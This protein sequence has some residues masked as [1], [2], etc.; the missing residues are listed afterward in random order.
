[1]SKT[2]K[3]IYIYRSDDLSDES[4]KNAQEQILDDLYGEDYVF[5]VYEDSSFIADEAESSIL[6]Q[7]YIKE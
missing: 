5:I 4:I 3:N 6:I 2:G 1:M 7:E